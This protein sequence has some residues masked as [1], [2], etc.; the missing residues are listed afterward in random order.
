MVRRQPSRI[1]MKPVKEITNLTFSQRV[2]IF[3]KDNVAP[4][5]VGLGIFV[6]LILCV[7]LWI[8]SLGSSAEQA[9][10]LIFKATRGLDQR[11]AKYKEGEGQGLQDS[12]DQLQ[13]LQAEYPHTDAGIYSYLYIGHAYVAKGDYTQAIENYKN[14]LLFGSQDKYLQTLVKQR[15]AFCYEQTQN[16]EEAIKYHRT[17]V[18]EDLD[19]D[20]T[21]PP[22]GDFSLYS[23]GRNYEIL[24]E[25]GRAYLAFKELQDQYPDSQLGDQALARLSILT[26][27]KE[28]E[29]KEEGSKTESSSSVPTTPLAP[30]R[31]APLKRR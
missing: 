24:G 3:I 18:P 28:E 23:I 14:F 26:P 9:N 17:V 6:V 31:P 21:P 7:F 27:P 30:P 10:Y 1:I 12:I 25:S 29:I 5:L 16:Y 2:S 15:I 8:H 22:L 11:I 20:K 13:Y 19:R 4:L